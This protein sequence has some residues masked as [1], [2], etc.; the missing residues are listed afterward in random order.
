MN[1]AAISKGFSLT[2]L[3]VAMVLGLI[4]VGGV[5]GVFIANQ[6]TARF[7]NTLGEIQQVSRHGFQLMSRDIRSAGFSGCGNVDRFMNVLNVAGVQ[8]W[9]TWNGG[10]LGLQAPVA[11]INGLT[12]AA[13]T[14]ALRVMYSG[15]QSNGITAH[16]PPQFTLNGPPTLRAGDIAA[17]CDDT[18]TTIFEVSAVV[19][20]ALNHGMGGTINCTSNL[21]YINPLNCAAVPART[22]MASAMLMRFE[23]VV[24]FV[25]PS[26]DDAAISSLYRASMVGNSQVNEEVLFGISGLSFLYLD[27]T[28]R[29]LRAANAVTDWG[30]IVAVQVSMTIHDALL[31][32]V[33]VPDDVK[34]LNF[35]VTLRNRV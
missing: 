35:T 12:P 22:F 5:I 17:V 15:G 10:L 26:Q 34:T 23:S 16:V 3:M 28:T 25:A 6:N 19:G 11:A 31:G 21:G 13:N 29:Q 33:A 7:N 27:G 30:D 32:K 24:W 20:T 1:K 14:D 18:L 4:V 9:A 8:P 2:E